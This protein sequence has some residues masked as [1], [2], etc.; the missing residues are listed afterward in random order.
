MKQ[1]IAKLMIILTLA[2]GFTFVGQ[3]ANAAPA[4]AGTISGCYQADAGYGRVFWTPSGSGRYAAICHVD[5]DWFEE[6]VL[7][8]VDGWKITAV[9]NTWCGGT[10]RTFVRSCGSW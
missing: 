1:F 5:H 8:Q 10:I 9:S 4:H 3:V 6:V 7:R 2:T